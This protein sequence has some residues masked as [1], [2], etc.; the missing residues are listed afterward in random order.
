MTQISNK[1]RLS[2]TLLLPVPVLVLVLPLRPPPLRP[3]LLQNPGRFLAHQDLDFPQAL[4]IV[5]MLMSA[6]KMTKPA[7]A[8]R[9]VTTVLAA[10]FASVKQVL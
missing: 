7:T 3:L 4:T 8:V 10:T 9:I 1:R 2:P 5:S 6:Q